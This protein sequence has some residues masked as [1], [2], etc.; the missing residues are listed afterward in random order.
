LFDWSV[1]DAAEMW[2]ARKYSHYI[3]PP[4]LFGLIKQ[5]FLQVFGRSDI[6]TEDLRNL[7]E[8]LPLVLIANKANGESYPLSPAEARSALRRAGVKV[9]SSVAH[10]LALEMEQARPEE[11]LARWQTV[12]GP[13]FQDIWPLDVDLQTSATTFKLVQILR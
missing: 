8:W 6:P 1:P 5:P 10:R 9:L 13:V 12:V 7:A 2:S 4:K 3:G 11:K